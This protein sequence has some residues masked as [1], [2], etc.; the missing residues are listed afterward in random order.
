MPR[1]RSRIRIALVSASLVGAATLI[2]AAPVA[3]NA[4]AKPKPA[5]PHAK[6]ASTMHGDFNGDGFAD[7]AVGVDLKDVNGQ[8][9]AGAVSVIYGSAAGLASGGNQLFTQD[10]PG[11][12]DQAEVG[13][14]FGR[15]MGGGDFNGDGFFDLAIGDP[16]EDVD[17]PN[18]PIVDAG[19]VQIMY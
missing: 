16:L 9:D 2:F 15:Y 17:G 13:D 10:S 19:A 5:T 8:A 4:A 18:G 14:Q 11:M 6:A 7:A 12:L 1:I 3:S